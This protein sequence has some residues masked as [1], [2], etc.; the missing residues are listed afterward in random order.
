MNYQ[1]IPQVQW[2]ESIGVAVTVCDKDG[3]VLYQNARSRQT[4]AR[5]G[6]MRGRSLIP[7]HNERSQAIIAHMLATGDSNAYTITKAGQRKLIYQTP[8]RDT[9]GRIAGLVELSMV[10]PADLPHYNRD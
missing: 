4:F 1:E 10:L 2:A 3:I 7:C 5:S 6:D 9:D 8:W